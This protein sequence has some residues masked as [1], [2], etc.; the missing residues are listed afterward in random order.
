VTRWTRWLSTLCLFP[1]NVFSLLV[2][3]EQREIRA[4]KAAAT[5]TGKPKAMSA[6]IAKMFAAT[7]IHAA[8]ITGGIRGWIGKLRNRPGG[9]PL[10]ILG[11]LIHPDTLLGYTHPDVRMRIAKLT[12]EQQ[13]AASAESLPEAVG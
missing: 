9:K 13:H 2:D 5:V 12:E 4:D 3:W 7:T 11:S 10:A 6:A 1:C 8:P